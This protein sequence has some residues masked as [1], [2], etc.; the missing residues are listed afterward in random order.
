MADVGLNPAARDGGMAFQCD[1]GPEWKREVSGELPSG[2]E[3][4]STYSVHES[5]WREPCDTLTSQPTN[6]RH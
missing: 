1:A 2:Q 3:E 6:H 4:L 5:T